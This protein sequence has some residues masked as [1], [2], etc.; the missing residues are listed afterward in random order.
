MRNLPRI[1]AS[2]AL[3]LCL[4]KAGLSQAS[5]SGAEPRL[6]TLPQAI[7][8]AL[9]DNIGL[10]RS[11]LVA[12]SRS[13][14]VEQSEKEFS[15]ELSLRLSENITHSASSS[16]GIFE[17]EGRWSDSASAT[18][19]AS[20][21]LYNGG[22]RKAAIEQAV[23]ELEAASLDFDRDRQDL[24]ADTVSQF[25][26]AVL[27]GK[28]IE[29][30]KEELATRQEELERIQFDVENGIRTASQFLR[31]KAQVANS[32]RS[33]AQA[34]NNYA[35]S[36]FRLK[37]TLNI[38]A[39]VQILCEDP[40]LGQENANA[41]PPVDLT[42]SLQ[43]LE[44]R[45]DLSAQN[46]RLRSAKEDLKIA[47]SGKR[48]R[49]TSS[50]SLGTSYSSNGSRSFSDQAFID[51]PRLGAGV[52]VS[53]P[54]FDRR[55]TEL[56]T[57]RSRIGIQQEEL[58][59][60]S[61]RLAAKTALFQAEQDYQTAQFQLVSSR[62][63]LEA[64]EAAL[65]AELSRFEA[66]AATLLEVNSLRSS[67]LD[68]AVAVEEARFSVFTSRLEIAFAD[69]SIESFLQQTLQIVISE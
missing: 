66:G 61:L 20:L 9:A 60:E 40:K 18:L 47:K 46:A 23:Q 17:G 48:L 45:A 5:N 30:Q 32:E 29:I 21:T 16:G 44:G 24:L 10:Q 31:Q 50:A 65:E 36:L 55:R 38:P 15:P 25:L 33:L 27:R 13:T 6:L 19:N 11:D 62:Q 7:N 43:A 2:S 51:Q 69:G 58:I 52:T 67:R 68:A 35:S 26:F 12:Q 14:R 3:C 28:E 34:R 49:V 56:D 4:A 8:L 39:D 63:Q 42:R 37:N 53:I 54:I 1:L 22:A 57:V 41:L 59:L 64:T